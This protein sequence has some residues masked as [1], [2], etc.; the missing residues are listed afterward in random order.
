MAAERPLGVL[1]AGDPAVLPVLRA[2]LEGQP[3]ARPAEAR[4]DVVFVAAGQNIQAALDQ[5]A[6]AARE[7]PGAQLALA[8]HPAA[9]ELFLAA[10]RLGV[11]EALPAADLERKLPGALERMA[12]RVRR[13]APASSGRS[14]AL[15]AFI[16]AKGGVGVTTL[17]VGA[18]RELARPGPGGAPRESVLVDM[19]LPYGES[20]LFLGIT[21][22][23]SLA[24]I[25]AREGALQA[26][27][28]AECAERHVSGL[29]L[30][31]LPAQLADAPAGL[32]PELLCEILA[33]LR[34]RHDHVS[35]DLGIYIDDLTLRVMGQ[36]DG[37]YLVGVQ[38]MACV[39]NIRRF[40]DYVRP[41]GEVRLVVNRHLS[42]CELSVEDMEKAL[43]LKCFQVI[44]NDYAL[45]L[46]A[47]NLGRPVADLAPRSAVSRA[48]AALASG[49]SGERAE[50]G[51]AGLAR[52]LFGRA[53]G[54]R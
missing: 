44:P 28:A 36:A 24:E 48:L 22:G 39:R 45:T 53:P 17:A 52:R 42:D 33:E 37:V 41:Q 16:G 50:S 25:L 51:L 32:S 49:M 8:A 6:Q 9:P 3:L 18:A 29:S 19:N 40:L 38:S 47:I 21:P 31:A 2:A 14:G 43:G 1:L 13:S 5:L 20:P 15:H 4:P 10:L 54:G 12:G 7:H 46:E 26:R 34:S 35:V 27:A 30:L 23:T 11:R